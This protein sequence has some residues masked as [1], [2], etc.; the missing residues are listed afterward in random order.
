MSTR[1]YS[2]A[3]GANLESVVEAAGAAVVTAAIELTV[4][5]ATTIVTDS[6][7]TRQISKNEVL[8]AIDLF[9]QYITRSVWPP[10]AS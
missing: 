3:P 5:M 2:V 7:V 6:G 9:E 1:R 8:I 10:A 4:D